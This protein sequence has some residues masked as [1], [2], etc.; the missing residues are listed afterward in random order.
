MSTRDTL[1][2]R[3][4]IG[5]LSLMTAL[6]LLLGAAVNVFASTVNIYDNAG[7]LN[8]S[9]VRQ[10][11]SSLPYPVSI[12]TVNGYNGSN[13]NFDAEARSKVTSSNM[14][15]IAINTAGHVYITGGSSV[16]LTTS[17]YQQASNTFASDMRSNG[18]DFTGAT[19]GALSSLRGALGSRGS[20]GAV[21]AP[22]GLFGLGNGA[23]CCI[24][25][26]VLAG[27]LFFAFMRRRS[28]PGFGGFGGFF[29]RNRGVPPYGPNQPYGPYNQPYPP[30]YGP[31]YNQGMNPW[32]AGG[33]GAAAGGFLGYELGKEQGEREA[34]ENYQGDQGGNFGGGDF[35]GGAGADWG[36]GGDSGGGDFGGGAGGD[37]GGGGGGDFG[38][39]GGDAGGG[40]GSNF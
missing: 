1:M 31:G 21:P 27:I 37:W 19:V 15:V 16:P 10:E 26:L 30:N 36:G 34:R 20:G 14:I 2:K 38:G 11:A 25:L 3:L 9:Q 17:D 35:G 24:G 18:R 8:Q 13:A 12:Y 39:G 7:V 6:A 32:A 40:G 28:R 22:G 23:L 5:L 33:L 4:G 29:N